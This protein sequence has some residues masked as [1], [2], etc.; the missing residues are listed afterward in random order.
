MKEILLNNIDNLVAA[1]LW[2]LGAIVRRLRCATP[3]VMHHVVAARLRKNKNEW[4]R[5]SQNK[6][7][8]FIG[9]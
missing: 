4:V 5:V 2:L 1:R 6:K 7:S 8:K 3:P 9:A